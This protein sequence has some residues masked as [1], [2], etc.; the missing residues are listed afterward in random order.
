M[1][2]H[3]G[4]D[5]GT[6]FKKTHRRM[7][8]AFIAILT[9]VIIGATVI[10]C[11]SVCLISCCGILTDLK[12]VKEVTWLAIRFTGYAIGVLFILFS[13]SAMIRNMFIITKT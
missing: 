7:L 9:A 11:V 4:D 1:F 5:S 13:L 2:D 6:Y 10:F 3:K 12:R 8:A